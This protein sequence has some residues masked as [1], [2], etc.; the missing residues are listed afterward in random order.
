[1]HTEDTINKA[2][3][4]TLRRAGSLLGASE[5]DQHWGESKWACLES[6]I[7]QRAW[8]KLHSIVC[9]YKNCL[10]DSGFQNSITPGIEEM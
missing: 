5:P 3:T 6:V 2:I 9:V 1:M 10:R 7:D 4:W 8:K